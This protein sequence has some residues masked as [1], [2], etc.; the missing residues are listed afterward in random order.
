MRMYVLLERAELRRCAR[1]G[2][3]VTARVPKRRGHEAYGQ[4]LH[5]RDEFERDYLPAR[6]RSYARGLGVLDRAPG[7]VLDVG[8]NYGHFL[9]FALGQ[10]WEVT[11]AE[12]SAGARSAGLDSVRQHLHAEMADALALGPFDLV[13]LWD[14]LEH[15]ADP[16]ALLGSI[17]DVLT[18]AGRL[19]VRVP[20]GRALVALSGPSR[21][22]HLALCH[23]TNPEEH[24]HQWT[25]ASL[26][27]VA[28]RVGLEVIEVV[29]SDEDERV[30]SAWGSWDRPVRE[31]LHRGADGVPYEFTA[32]LQ[33]LGRSR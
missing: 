8:A 15:V 7:K 25:P 14:V 4:H 31:A 28:R 12:A 20:D 27:E 21:Q 10:G 23:P 17:R 22:L 9:D 29:E 26:G 18:P 2:H 16:F 33:R 1:C 19:L 11:G 32:V 6:R 24:P 5:A 13:T 30:I 3:A